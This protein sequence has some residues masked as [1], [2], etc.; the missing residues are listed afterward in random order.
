MT[1]PA[2][3]PRWADNPT[4][5]RT[6]PAEA[7]KDTGFAVNTKLPAQFFNWLHGLTYDWIKWF[8]EYN[9]PHARV[10]RGDADF[11]AVGN[12]EWTTEVD[13]TGSFFV[14]ADPYE[15][16]ITTTG[17]YRVDCSLAIID[18]GSTGVHLLK[19]TRLSSGVETT[20][21]RNSGYVATGTGIYL[22]AGGEIDCTAGDY[23]YAT[24]SST[25]G[26]THGG[27]SFSIRWLGPPSW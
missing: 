25:V 14:G 11:D 22:N 2:S 23:I 10:T 4:T 5:L 6:E 9:A 1:I 13:D 12:V 20:I 15:F 19:L 3:L 7:T 18:T 17:R 16:A 26:A 21:A 8:S 27:G 24:T